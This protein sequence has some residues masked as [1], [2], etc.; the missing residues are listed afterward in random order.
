MERGLETLEDAVEKVFGLQNG[1]ST[2]IGKLWIIITGIKQE[3]IATVNWLIKQIDS[4]KKG[5]KILQQ[6]SR[7]INSD[8]LIKS[9]KEFWLFLQLLQ[10]RI[11]NS[12]KYFWGSKR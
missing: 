4:L 9:L 6:W 2:D 12:L 10:W 7:N 1:T 8:F 11:N 5:V 3:G